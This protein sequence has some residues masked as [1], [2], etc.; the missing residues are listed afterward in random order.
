MLSLSKKKPIL[1]HRF[2]KKNEMD[3]FTFTDNA[4]KIFLGMILI[5]ILAIVYGVVDSDISGHRIWVSA[6]INGWFFFGIAIIGTFFLAVNSAAQA[7][8]GVVMQRVFEAVSLFVPIGALLLILVFLASTFHL[9]HIYHWMDPEAAAHDPIIAGKRAY[10]NLPFW[11]T[12]ALIFL[13]VWTG[14][15]LWFRKKSLREDA[16]GGTKWYKK[17][18]MMSAIFLVFFGFTSMVASWDWLM[19]IDVHWFST[20][21]G[22]Y[23][24]S[25]IWISGMVTVI[26]LINWLKSRGYLPNVNASHI[27]DMGKWIF[28]IS[29]LWTYLFFS[30]FMLIWYSNIP[31]EVAYFIPR[32]QDYTIPF[33]GMVMV[34]FVVP[35]LFLMSKTTKRNR[36]LL[37]IV[38]VIIFFGH[39]L[40]V[41]FLV[42]PGTMQNNGSVGFV[43]LGMMIG[44]LGLFL[45]VVFRALAQAPLT[46]RNHPLMEE[47][48]HHHIN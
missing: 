18:M 11:W 30:Q 46:V 6:L 25:G 17:S 45:F 3:Q 24:F 23:V 48:L 5:G 42:T 8:W 32:M 14:I 41:Y 47:S 9:N 12:R 22:W 35:M 10:L 44:Y 15:T 34:N 13:G 29:F 43:E 37:S 20:L 31:E 40:D 36:K 21:Y 16:E 28:A 26:L 7:A 39:W 27:H 1:K 38:S 33:W 19:S 4:K 2:S